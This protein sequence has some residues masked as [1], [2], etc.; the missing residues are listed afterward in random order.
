MLA[1]ASRHVVLTWSVA[2]GVTGVGFFAADIWSDPRRGP[3]WIAVLLGLVAW[4]LAGAATLHRGRIARG[5]VVWGA[6]YLLAFWLGAVW[7]GWF[8]RNRV[9]GVGSAGLVGALLGWS[10]GAAVGALA[11]ASAGTTPQR[12]LR[13]TAFAV[14]WG[15]SFLVAGYVGIVAALVMAQVA[16]G[17]LVFLGSDWTALAVGWA[18]GAAV[19]GA[20]ASTLGMAAGRA[21]VGST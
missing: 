8:E 7:A 18:L 6:A 4:S 14:A 21:I 13:A 17:L 9:G 11:S 2:W 12:A 16:K 5:L 1:W 3:L 20:L 15:L 10:V 19:G